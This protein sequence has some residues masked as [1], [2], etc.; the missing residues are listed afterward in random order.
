MLCV[1]DNYSRECLALV[2][3]TSIGG[4]RLARELDKLIDY[5][6]KPNTIV[7]DNG[8]EMTPNATLKW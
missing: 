6:G 4:E 8:T 3:D 7:S 1:I 5:R 2:S